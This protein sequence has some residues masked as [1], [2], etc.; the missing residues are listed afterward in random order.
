[1]YFD[2]NYDKSKNAISNRQYRCNCGHSV[3]IRPEEDK[4]LC[5]YCNRY[6]F[7]NEKKSITY[8]TLISRLKR[9][10]KKYND[11]LYNLKVK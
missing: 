5:K 1:M 8:I 9:A 2:V 6:V 11:D 4:H 10:Y 7:K 3:Y